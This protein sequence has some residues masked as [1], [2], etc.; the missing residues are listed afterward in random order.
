ML[1]VLLLLLAQ[2]PCAPN[3]LTVV[4]SCK[5]GVVSACDTLRLSEPELVAKLEQAVQAAAA[6]NAA[7]RAAEA[8][9]A[10]GET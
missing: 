7:N 2:V 5:Q 10:E 1:A 9:K 6:M 4:C 8:L 3:D